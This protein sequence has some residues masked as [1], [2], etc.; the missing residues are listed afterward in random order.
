M[1]NHARE[2]EALKPE[3]T[4]LREAQQREIAALRGEFTERDSDLRQKLAV[5]MEAHGALR[6][7]HAESSGAQQQE[8]AAGT[9]E[10]AE[11]RRQLEPIAQGLGNMK[12]QPG[13]S[14]SENQIGDLAAQLGMPIK[15]LPRYEN[16]WE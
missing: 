12:Q 13:Q 11:I 2:L 16:A 3:I 14:S 4:D 10:I 7:Q 5:V 6:Q 1:T 9:E 8:N 15:R